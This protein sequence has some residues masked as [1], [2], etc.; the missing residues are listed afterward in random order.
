MLT[1]G[2]LLELVLVPPTVPRGRGTSTS[3]AVDI[4]LKLLCPRG[5][6]G[7]GQ[8]PQK[9]GS[10]AGE[11]LAKWVEKT[12]LRIVR[13][14]LGREVCRCVVVMCLLLTIYQ[15]GSSFVKERRVSQVLG[16]SAGSQV[17]YRERTGGKPQDAWAGA[18]CRR[19]DHVRCNPKYVT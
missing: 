5:L 13:F 1:L 16:W 9:L 4:M 12:R 6:L 10:D 14:S 3:V 17:F 15:S 8:V 7:L 11:K 2:L 19:K 18:V